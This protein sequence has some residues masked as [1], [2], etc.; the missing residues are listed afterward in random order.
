MTSPNNDNEIDNSQTIGKSMMVIAWIL[1]IGFLTY[2]FGGLEDKQLN[3]N[4]SPNSYRTQNAIEVILQRNKYGHY[5]VSGN[6]NQ[7]EAVFMLDTGATLVAVPGELQRELGLISGNMH[8]T[9]TAN[10]RAKAYDTV[11]DNLEIGDIKLTNVRAS[12]VPN[13]QGREILLGMSVLK[14]L[15]FT[16]KGKQLTLRQ[17]K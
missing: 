17:I 5:M 1:A 11:I 16:Q 4:E 13:M 8:Y 15:E 12:I 3:P 10:G 9:H 7:H 14:Q 2:I 6:V